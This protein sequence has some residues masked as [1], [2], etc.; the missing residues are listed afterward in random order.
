M[1]TVKIFLSDN[2]FTDDI[3]VPSVSYNVAWFNVF[4][5]YKGVANIICYIVLSYN[6]A[7]TFIEKIEIILLLFISILL[8]KL[9]YVRYYK[10]CWAHKTSHVTQVLEL[11]QRGTMALHLYKN[12][13]GEIKSLINA[14]M[15]L[16]LTISKIY[17]VQYIVYPWKI[18]KLITNSWNFKANVYLFT[19][20]TSRMWWGT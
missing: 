6:S 11:K 10:Y 8:Y 13:F 16:T 15:T 18:M 2:K 20:A 4:R 19:A 3:E 17:C 7:L 12:A 14:N 9:S 5:Y 1:T